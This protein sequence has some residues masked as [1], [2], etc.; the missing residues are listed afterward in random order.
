MSIILGNKWASHSWGL[1][2]G[3]SPSCDFSSVYWWAPV[4]PQACTGFLQDTLCL[5]ARSIPFLWSPQSSVKCDSSPSLLSR[6]WVCFWDAHRG[7]LSCQIFIITRLITTPPS[8]TCF[9][10]RVMWPARVSTRHFQKDLGSVRTAEFRVTPGLP[11]PL[12]FLSPFSHLHS[13]VLEYY[14]D[15]K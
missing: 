10:T 11:P 14:K 8:P 2:P 5:T 6:G 1:R 13:L 9:S 15:N 4:W 7:H 12:F 3:P